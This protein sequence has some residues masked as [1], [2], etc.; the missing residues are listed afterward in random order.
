MIR[1]R[2]PSS[3]AMTATAQVFEFMAVRLGH[4]T[5][6][7]NEAARIWNAQIRQGKSKRNVTQIDMIEALEEIIDAKKE[8]KQ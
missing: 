4:T 7:I 6:E 8:A 3:K 1:R 5:E 2:K